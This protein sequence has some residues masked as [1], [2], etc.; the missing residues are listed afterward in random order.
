[1]DAKGKRVW[2]VKDKVADSS[3]AP[4]EK[5]DMAEAAPLSST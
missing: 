4:A 5:P 1:M 3:Q 2:T